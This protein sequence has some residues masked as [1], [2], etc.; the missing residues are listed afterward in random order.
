[1]A[2]L[3]WNDV[4]AGVIVGVVAAVPFVLAAQIVAV[5]ADIDLDRDGEFTP[6]LAATI[7]LGLLAFVAMGAG[8]FIA[9]RRQPDVPLSHALVAALG[10]FAVI[11]VVGAIRLLA[12]GDSVSI[13]QIALNSVLASGAG[14]VGGLLADRRNRRDSVRRVA[15]AE[16]EFGRPLTGRPA[17]EQEE[18]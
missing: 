17:G 5:L 18:S 3:E 16:A 14:L 15:A 12:A 2:E 8:G 6:A 1:M 7:A 11:Q 4:R 10:A 13:A 9:A